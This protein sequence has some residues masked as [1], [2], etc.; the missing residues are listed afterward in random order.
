MRVRRDGAESRRNDSGLSLAPPTPSDEGAELLVGQ[1]LDQQC[2]DAGRL[3]AGERVGRDVPAGGE[4]GGEAADGLLAMRAV[5]GADPR[6]SIP[7]THWLSDARLI[8]SRSVSAHQ[9]R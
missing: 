8:G 9:R 3:H 6:S 5:P 1:R 4:P 2:W 7:A